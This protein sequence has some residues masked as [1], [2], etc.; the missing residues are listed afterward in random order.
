MEK[1]R[2]KDF[3]IIPD[4]NSVR[5]EE[6]SDEVYFSSKYS[7]YISNSR[8]K[9]INP[10]E[11]GSP[12][13]FKTNPKIST[14][15]LQRGS[16]VHEVILQ[17]EEFELAPKVG[18]PNA[19]LGA[20][21]DEIEK[22]ISQTEGEYDIKDIIRKASKNVDYFSNSIDSKIDIIEEAWNEYSKKLIEIK[23]NKDKEQIILSD[24]DWDVVN[25]CIESLQANNE[26]MAKF[27]PKDIFGDPIESHCEDAL[28][29][30]FIVIY[31]GNRCATLRFKLKIDNWTIDFE[32]KVITLNDL[33]TTGK[34]LNNFMKQDGSFDHYHYHRQFGAY[35]TVLWYYCMKKYGI[36][37]EQGWK[38]NCNVC[39]V[40]T[41]PNYWSRCYTVNDTQLRRGTKELNELL[42]R[43]AYYEIFGYDKEVEFE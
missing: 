3:R 8:L 41:I 40:E 10:E 35:S 28:F 5:G 1:V 33:K 18:K 17:P 32:N 43:V 13:L 15:S 21:M 23:S 7:K 11:G 38:L 39:V 12:K 27:H 42:K 24:G 19:K 36:S 4:F 29:M 31:K 30:D 20:M 16:A 6:I 34:T 9:N 25:S 37:K 22:L 14:Q 26:I 2:F